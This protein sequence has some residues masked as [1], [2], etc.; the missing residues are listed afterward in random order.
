MSTRLLVFLLVSAAFGRTNVVRAEGPATT[1]SVPTINPAAASPIHELSEFGPLDKPTDAQ[2]TYE[3]AVE[4]LRTTGGILVVPTA[5]WKTLKPLPLQGLIRTPEPP[6]E[7]KKWQTGGGVTVLSADAQQTIIQLP[8]LSGAKIE[9]RLQLADGDSLP[10]W[11]T[12]PAITLDSKLVSGSVSYLDWIQEPV[13]KGLDRKFYVPTIRGLRPNSFVNIHGGPGYGGGVTRACIK[14]LGYDAEKQLHYVVADTD[15]DHK[16]G[17]ILHNKSNTGLI[18]MTQTSHNDNQTYDMKIIRNQFAHGDT[19][20]YYAD[21]NYMSNV[22]SAAGDENGNVYAAFI[23]SKENN[24]KGKVE[25]IDWSTSRLTFA[26]AGAANVETLGDSRPLINHNPAKHITAGKVLIVPP[27]DRHNA[28]DVA[29]TFEGKQYPA[30]IGKNPKTGTQELYFGGLIRG[31]KDAPWTKDVVGRYFAVNTPEE[32]TPGG[33]F[34]WY[35]ISGFKQNEDGT[36]DITIRRYWWGA[37]DAGSPLLYQHESYTWDGHLKPLDYI[38]APGAYV[39]DVSRAIA[40]G[41]RG[42]QRILGVAP[43]VAQA[44]KFDF[45][46]GDAIEQA[47]GPDP[48]KPQPFRCWM[49]EDIPGAFPS[50]V[51]DIANQG[52]AS[53]YAVFNLRGGP[54]TLEDAAKRKEQKPSWDNYMVM[55]AAAGV[56]LNF[57]AD[58]ADAALLFQQLNHEQPIKW[59]YGGDETT[60]AKEAALTVTK[61]T[62]EFNFAGNGVRTNGPISGAT[63]LSGDATPARNLRGKNVAVAAESKSIRVTFPT[64]EA[65][66]DYAVFIEQSWLSERAV[67]EKGPEGFTVTFAVAAPADAKLDWMLVR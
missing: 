4:T 7:T 15:L 16:V 44:T 54:A 43:H 9:R 28:R 50:A 23:R 37:K 39:N 52:Q 31:D 62:G 3:K 56:G 29:P 30:Y 49:W 48:F 36:K 35:E 26:A 14:S 24:F 21:F 65:D 12:H 19:Y 8:P 46:A 42:G 67:S 5:S 18:H 34:R 32:K 38:I 57:K 20:M 13:E 59:Y 1:T 66:G 60:P 58:F 61:A 2:A 63:G 10:H 51:F 25:A 33:N 45:E 27:N 11:G 40:G 22:H 41:D 55:E 53:R 47:I 6:A 64:P 17:A